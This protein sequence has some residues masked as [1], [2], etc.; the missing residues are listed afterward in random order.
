MAIVVQYLWLMSLAA[1][2][3]EEGSSS[4]QARRHGITSC[5]SHR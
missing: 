3:V 4:R 2:G 5:Q 1:L